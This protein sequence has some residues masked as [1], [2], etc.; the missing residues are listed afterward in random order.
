MTPGE[1]LK[2]SEGI[3]V[4][5][6]PLEYLNLSQGEGG[7]YSHLGT[8]NLDFL[9]WNKNGRLLKCP[10]YAPCSCTCIGSTEDSNRIWQS[11]HE[12]LYADGTIDF[13]TWVQ[14]HDDS[15]LSIGTVLN[16]GELLGH[17]GTKGNVTGDHVHFNFA[18]GKYANWEQVPPNNNWQLKNSIHI[19]NAT[20][21]NDTIIINGYN[22]P[23][24]IF[25]D[26]PIPSLRKQNKFPWVLYARKLRNIDTF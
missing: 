20:Y 2:N 16:Q 4:L 5:L 7:D 14:A 15:P 10:Y 18:R 24:K 25:E 23:W 17:T 13:V 22:Y 6:F 8:Y 11:N 12:V 9:G 21:V 3:E 19:Y 1:K 26:I